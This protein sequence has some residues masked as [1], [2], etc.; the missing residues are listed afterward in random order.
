VLRDSN[1]RSD[2]SGIDPFKQSDIDAVNK[3]L[4]VPVYDLLDR[5]GKRWR[6]L[7]GLM[8]AEAFGRTNLEDHEANKDIFFTCGMTELTH[9]GSLIVDDI[10][11][12][13]LKRR[14]DICTYKKFGID[15]AINAGNFMYFAPMT[16]LD[17]FVFNEQHKSAMHKIF[18]EE[19]LNI[20]FGQAWD[21]YWHNQKGKVP[22]QAQYLQMVENKTSVLPRMCLRMIAEQTN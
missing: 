4:F 12:S 1:T 18:L 3:A 13:S 21:I 11:D 17:T 16:K 9:N 2:V 20:H 22:T 15:I 14:G 8:M 5:G 6:P 7:L 10:E 19:M